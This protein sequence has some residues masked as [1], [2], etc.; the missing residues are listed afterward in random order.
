MNLPGSTW[1]TMTELVVGVSESTL[2]IFISAAIIRHEDRV[3]QCR[4]MAVTELLLS[5]LHLDG[6]SSLRCGLLL[7]V[8]GGTVLICISPLC[9]R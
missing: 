7:G 4:C 5:L 1:R 2:A 6:M 3:Y 9:E 8:E